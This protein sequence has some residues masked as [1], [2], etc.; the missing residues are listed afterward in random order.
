MAAA[1]QVALPESLPLLHFSKT[2]EVLIW[3]LLRADEA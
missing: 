1:A 2:L 3:P